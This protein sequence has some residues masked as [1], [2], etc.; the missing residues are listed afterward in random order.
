MGKGVIV[1]DVVSDKSDNNCGV[2]SRV[3]EYKTESELHNH[4][5]V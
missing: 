5:S 1:T 3:R 4:V 2:I